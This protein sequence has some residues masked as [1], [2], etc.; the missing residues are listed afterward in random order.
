MQLGANTVTLVWSGMAAPSCGDR[1]AGDAVENVVAL[2]AAGD[3]RNARLAEG[4]RPASQSGAGALADLWIEPP[5]Y[6]GKAP[7]YLYRA[8]GDL[9]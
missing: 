6:T 8:G 7:I 3:E 2:V 5:E 9:A 1:I 4:F